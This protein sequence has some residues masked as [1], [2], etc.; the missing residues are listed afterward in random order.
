[1]VTTGSALATGTVNLFAQYFDVLGHSISR[2]IQTILDR[3]PDASKPFEIRRVKP[4]ERRI[5]GGFNH[6]RVR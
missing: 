5:V 3:V 2:L 6:K 1:M 4:E